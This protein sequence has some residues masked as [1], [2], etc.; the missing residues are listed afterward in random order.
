MAGDSLYLVAVGQNDRLT[1]FRKSTN[2]G[3]SWLPAITLGPGWQWPQVLVQRNLV[4]VFAE[5]LRPYAA[6]VYYAR[7]T[8]GGQTWASMWA[9]SSDDD[10]NSVKPCLT[11]IDTLAVYA[12]WMDQKYSPYSWTGD[13]FIRRSLDGGVTWAPEESLTVEHRA[14]DSD[15]IAQ[16][17]TLHLV[18]EDDRVDPG[19]NFELFYRMSTDRGLSW[20]SEIRLTYAPMHSRSPSLGFGSKYLH[21]VWAD[22]RLDTTY[23]WSWVYHKRK[24][25]FPSGVEVFPSC[26]LSVKSDIR[27]SPN[28]ARTWV[29]IKGTRVG[30]LALYDVAG[31]LV[32]RLA[33]QGNQRGSSSVLWDCRNEQEEEVK[34]GVYFLRFS[35]SGPVHKVVVV[36]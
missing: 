23:N 26:P 28:P 32:R 25:L 6:E 5:V 3:T 22:G 27:I 21:L 11:G 33:L 29:L 36:R 18:S 19:R 14:W 8:D 10:L 7:S 1:Y 2:R 20:D 16:G 30:E 12:V 24:V 31:R 34:S 15:A 4:H 9:M 13:I 35:G 17:D